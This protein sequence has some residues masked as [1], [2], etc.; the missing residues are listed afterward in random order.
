MLQENCYVAHDET[1]ECVIVDCGAFYPYEQQAIKDYI[2][3]NKLTPKHLLCT[4]GHIDHIFGNKFIF[5]AYGLCPEVHVKDKYLTDNVSRQA[6][7][8]LGI[9]LQEEQPEVQNYFTAADIIRFGNHTLTIIE[10]PGHTPGSIFFYCKE[11]L[12]AFSG[13]TLF[14]QSIGRTDLEGG[15]MFQ[16]IQTLRFIS[17][18]P[19]ETTLFPGHGERTTIGA[20]L[21]T[22]PY[23]DR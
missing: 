13:D 2:T 5:D 22:N 3:Q 4:H 14:H 16:M 1:N 10:T 6:Q 17:Q 21:A 11:E 20:E 12:F 23:I 9:T 18:L 8:L 15:S 7:L 19:D